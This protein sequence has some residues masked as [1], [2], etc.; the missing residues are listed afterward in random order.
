M[1][2]KAHA[3]NFANRED[4]KTQNLHCGFLFRSNLKEWLEVRAE[5]RP[6]KHRITSSEAIQL[7]QALGTLKLG[8][9]DHDLLQSAINSECL[10]GDDDTKIPCP[11]TAEKV[12]ALANSAQG[13]VDAFKLS[14]GKLLFVIDDKASAQ[15]DWYREWMRGTDHEVEDNSW[16]EEAG[17]SEWQWP[18]IRSWVNFCLT[19]NLTPGTGR[20]VGRINTLLMLASWQSRRQRRQQIG[21]TVK[22]TVEDLCSVL[23]R[24]VDHDID[25]DQK[26]DDRDGEISA[27][28]REIGKQWLARSK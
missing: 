6:F 18:E 20:V 15:F 27:R 5:N 23:I 14:V 25:A 13:K 28:S 17:V 12:I 22:A 2:E 4:G 10:V 8:Y 19:K 11:L 26:D 21:D 1:L 7:S 24:K 16:L 3:D 9:S